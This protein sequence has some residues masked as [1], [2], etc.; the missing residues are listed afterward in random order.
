MTDI[1]S[2]LDRG[3]KPYNTLRA[4]YQTVFMIHKVLV[5]HHE[6][7]LPVFEKDI[8]FSGKYDSAMISGILQAISSI[9]QEIIGRPTGFKKLQFHGFVVTGAYFEGFSVYVFS[10]T[11][12]VKEIE[13]GLQDFI[14]WFSITFKSQRID[15]DGSLDV[16]K[17]S[18][19]IIE[20]KMTQNIFLWLLYPLLLSKNQNLNFS[21][22]TVLSSGILDCLKLGRD[23]TS[24]HIIDHFRNRSEDEILYE[25]FNLV[26]NGFIE[27]SCND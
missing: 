3:L 17:I 9:G 4:I 12:L 27:T 23:C 18:Q 6:T 24:A 15:W 14:K 8:E 20:N 25:V 5:V 22:L 11:E 10:E 1:I 16:F 21:N 13:T 2:S 7:S 19:T 26:V